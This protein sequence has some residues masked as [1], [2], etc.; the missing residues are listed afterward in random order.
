MDLILF[1]MQNLIDNLDTFTQ[2]V[3]MGLGIWGAMISCLIITAESI[4]PFLP[5]CVFITIEFY[6]FG[7]P[8]G[9]I[10]SWFF[11]CLGCLLAFMYSRHFLNDWFYRHFVK[12]D[13]VRLKKMIEYVDNIPASTL[14]VLVAIPFTP[15]FLVNFACGISKM[16]VKKFMLAIAIG[17]PVMVYFWGYIGMTLIE[18]LTHP[19]YLLRIGILLLGTF[20]VSRILSRI[21]KFE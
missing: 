7:G 3:L 9:F 20:T 10:I 6:V 11:T 4:L 2:E 17:K 14:A 19:I 5:L 12:K 1:S 21:L 18:C 15:A 8:L 16:D 13:S